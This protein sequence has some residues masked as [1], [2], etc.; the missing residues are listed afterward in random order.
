MDSET[1]TESRKLTGAPLKM[2][3][4]SLGPNT[5]YKAASKSTQ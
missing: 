2:V 3:S 5:K 4:K 1:A